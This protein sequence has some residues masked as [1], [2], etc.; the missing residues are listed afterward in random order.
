VT[1]GGGVVE[2]GGETGPGGERGSQGVVTVKTM[3]TSRTRV[4]E[5]LSESGVIRVF[6]IR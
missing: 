5:S 2:E 1:G 4:T 6:P 3:W